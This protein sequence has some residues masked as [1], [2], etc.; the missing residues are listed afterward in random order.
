M[1]SGIKALVAL[2]SLA[3]SV[4]TG[5]SRNTASTGGVTEEDVTPAQFTET[6]DSTE[7]VTTSYHTV[8]EKDMSPVSKSGSAIRFSD[9]GAEVSGG[10]VSVNGSVVTLTKAGYYY[11]SGVCSDGQLVIDCGK[12]DD[13]FI[14]LEGL[15]L[16]C[17]TGP[18]I[19][20]KKADK[21]TITLAERSEN[22]LSDGKGYSSEMAEDTGAALFSQDTMVINGSGTLN[23]NGVYKDGI[24]SKDGLKLCGG[25]INV[26]AAED[27]II[28]KDYLLAAGGTVTVNS[29]CDGIKSTNSSDPE[30]GYITI[31]GGAFS[32]TCGNDGIQAET[33]LN[34]SGGTIEMTTGGGSS[35]VDHT[36]GGHWG[37]FHGRDDKF[38]FSGLTSSD[39]KSAESMKGLKAGNSVKIT[40]GSITADC[41]DDSIHSNGTITIDGGDFQLATGDDGIHAD[42]VLTIS[43]GEINIST[44]YEGLEACGVEISGGTITLRAS[45][46]GINASDSDT[47]DISPYISIS[48]GSVT[49]NA[50]GDGVDSNGTISMSGGTL[51]VF[52]PT[53]GADGA[54]DYDKSFAM[55]GG[56][57][58]ALGSSR[59][60]QAPSTLA[61]PCLSIYADVTA[62][63]TI[64]VRDADGNVIISTITPKKCESLIFST[65][66]F[67]NGSTYTVLADDRVIM[68]V[69]AADGVSGNGATGSGFGSWVQDKGPWG[70]NTGNNTDFTRPDKPDGTNPQNNG[71]NTN[72]NSAA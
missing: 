67:K 5:C 51:V 21:L 17:S 22:T 34:I 52:G 59:M 65:P 6:A 29:G 14:V 9:G 49:A 39:G 44:S 36:D 41:A 46:D 24:K 64:E 63:S 20:C 62:D 45:D 31:S 32:L 54:L 69:T 18:A 10:A 38:D 47:N 28:G 68:E 61:Q 37:D 4:N 42:T 43:S 12:D 19:L 7:K 55:S 16:T 50:D 30:K 1:R 25:T 11:I 8:S 57:L 58:I 72:E 53:S 35:T 3:I 2:C 48:G 71:T 33:D 23:V 66:D 15:E 27:G 26:T 56:T 70:G 40:G 60:A 13:V